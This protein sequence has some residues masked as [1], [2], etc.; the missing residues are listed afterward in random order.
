MHG[1]NGV[2]ECF[3]CR[4]II[5]EL[6]GRRE[7]RPS[8]AFL[9]ENK[10]NHF[11]EE[12]DCALIHPMRVHRGVETSDCNDAVMPSESIVLGIVIL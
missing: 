11:G 6:S 8:Q 3:A 7:G 9:V 2:S 1:G 10:V 12:K 5:M 4:S